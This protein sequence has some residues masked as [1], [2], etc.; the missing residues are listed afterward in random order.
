MHQQLAQLVSYQDV[1]IVMPGNCFSR[2][3]GNDIVLG[4]G[5]DAGPESSIEALARQVYAV[6]EPGGL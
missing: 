6:P 2:G 1:L 4:A 5:C 3:T